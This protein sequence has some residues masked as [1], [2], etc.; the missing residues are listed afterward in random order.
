MP[1]TRQDVIDT[2]AACEPGELRLILEAAGKPARGAETPRELA[3]RVTNAL[4]WAYCTPAAYASGV[5]TLDQMIQRTARRLRVQGTLSGEDAWS[6]LHSLTEALA[7]HAL[8]SQQGVRFDELRPDHQRRARGSI[9]PSMAWGG[10]SATSYGA[11]AAGR[12]F[13]Q[14]AGTPIGKI[15]P[16]IPQV[17]PWFLA[18]KKASSVAAV[19]GTPLSVALA[20][21]AVNQGLST[22]WRTV[23]PLLLSVGA[24]AASDR[25]TE[26]EEI[27]PA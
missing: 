1:T 21:V 11:G 9:L 27:V 13:L 15:L 24:L 16:W 6:R 2:L 5:V 8:E 7:A 25:V 17:R 26:V 22:R 23:L 10:T 19:V 18:I 12:L 20:V 3:T 14:F 4:W